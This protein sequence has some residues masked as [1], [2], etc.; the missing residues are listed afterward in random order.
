[1]VP[2]S[3]RLAMIKTFE[4]VFQD[5]AKERKKRQDFVADPCETRFTHTVPGYVLFERERMLAAVN[6]E[7]VRRGIPPVGIK[8]IDRVERLACGHV[9]YAHKYPL[10]CAEIA[11][12]ENEPGA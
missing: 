6:M 7:R 11:L 5:A 12:G 9:D 4:N 2:I 3:E 1:M 8:A 10:Y